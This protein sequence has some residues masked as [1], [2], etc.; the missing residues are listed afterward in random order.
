M[1]CGVALGV[2]SGSLLTIAKLRWTSSSRALRTASITC[3]VMGRATGRRYPA[4][5]T[6]TALS[7]RAGAGDLLRDWRQR[8]RLSQ[9]EL[10]GEADISTRHLSFIEPGRAQPSRSMLLRL[11]ERL[12]MPLRARNEMLA[13]AGFAGPYAQPALDAPGISGGGRARH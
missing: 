1:A 2:M 11:A 4:V 10:A 6:S 13:A 8:R 12:D 3:Q 5:M 7:P 9:L